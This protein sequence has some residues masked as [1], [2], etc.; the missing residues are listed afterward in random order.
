MLNPWLTLPFQAVRLGWETQ[1]FMADQM[2]RLAGFGSSDRK[3]AGNFVADTTALPTIDGDAPQPPTP[4]VEA[5]AS[6][7]TAGMTRRPIAG[8][9]QD[10]RRREDALWRSA[11]GHSCV[12]M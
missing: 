7:P 1:S 8:Q 4:P 12:V 10:Q 2:M 6:Q 9:S 5:R 11:L 3:A